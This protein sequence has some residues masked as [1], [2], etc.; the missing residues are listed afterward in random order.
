M[1]ESRTKFR[2]NLRVVLAS[3]AYLGLVLAIPGVGQVMFTG[4]IGVL[5]SLAVLMAVQFPILLLIRRLIRTDESTKD[6]S[7]QDKRSAQ[8]RP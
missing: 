6:D 4:M 5:V 8:P 3:L 2:F 7:D 1:I